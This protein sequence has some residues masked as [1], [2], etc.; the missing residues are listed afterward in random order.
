MRLDAMKQV[1]IHVFIRG[2]LPLSRSFRDPI[3]DYPNRD[4]EGLKLFRFEQ[5]IKNRCATSDLLLH[6]CHSGLK[7]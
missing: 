5:M 2:R 1:E 3:E 6:L 7:E 4:S